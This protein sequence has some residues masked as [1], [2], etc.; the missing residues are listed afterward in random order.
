[1]KFKEQSSLFNALF[2]APMVLA[3]SS[4]LLELLVQKM[5]M[6]GIMVASLEVSKHK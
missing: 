5:M 1:M 6:M 3:R 4:Q 2:A